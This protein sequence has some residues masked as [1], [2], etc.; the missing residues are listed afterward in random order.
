MGFLLHL[1]AYA[2]MYSCFLIYVRSKFK[3]LCLC[4]YLFFQ[5]PFPYKQYDFWDKKDLSCAFSSV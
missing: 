5:T 1:P 4:Y 3:E 2:R